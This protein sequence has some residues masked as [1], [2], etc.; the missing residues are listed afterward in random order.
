MSRDLNLGSPPPTRAQTKSLN[1]LIKR[2]IKLE[3][4]S[5]LHK[6]R[7]G[8]VAR[9]RGGNRLE[10]NARFP[11]EPAVNWSEGQ[12][13]QEMLLC[14]SVGLAPSD[15]AGLLNVGTVPPCAPLLHSACLGMFEA[16]Y[17]KPGNIPRS[18]GGV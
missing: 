18:G 8:E 15:L 6:Q 11:R 12:V 4:V 5:A 7:I 10:S 16:S 3:K 17:E 9:E 2:L 1:P 13:G 14:S